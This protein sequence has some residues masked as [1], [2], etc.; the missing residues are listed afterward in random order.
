[1]NA[2]NEKMEYWE[3]GQ[4]PIGADTA[5]HIDKGSWMVEMTIPYK[6]LGIKPPKPGDKWRI[7]LCR[8]RPEGKDFNSE[9]IVWAPLQRGFKDIANFGT[10]IFK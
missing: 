2:A 10:L 9:L 3:S 7:S 6:G 8:H 5:T 1:V 4:N